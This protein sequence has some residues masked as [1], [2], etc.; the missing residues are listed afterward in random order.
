MFQNILYVSM[1]KGLENPQDFSRVPRISLVV[2]VDNLDA[3]IKAKVP[4][5]ERQVLKLF[6]EPADVPYFCRQYGECVYA[7]KVLP[8]STFWTWGNFTLRFDKLVPNLL[9]TFEEDEKNALLRQLEGFALWLDVSSKDQKLYIK[10]K[11][12]CSQPSAGR[13]AGRVW[14]P[15]FDV[16]LAQGASLSQDAVCFKLCPA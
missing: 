6:V 14:I 5:N 4:K 11:A 10:R 9:E 12:Q 13:S 1:K 3:T 7:H 16:G 15:F 8:L 2:A